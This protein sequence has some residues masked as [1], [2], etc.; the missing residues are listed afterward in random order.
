MKSTTAPLGGKRLI[1]V[2]ARA[3][4]DTKAESLTILDLSRHSGVSDW[5]VV[6][7]GD[8]PIHN[9]AVAAAIRDGLE[10]HGTILWHI[11]GEEQGRWIL[12]DYS[13]VV[14]HVMLPELR[15][16]YQ[17]ELLREDIE[18]IDINNEAELDSNFLD[19]NGR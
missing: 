18:R 13:D 1:D 12:L 4:F 2:A 3:A 14:V 19:R 10:K 16:Y 11:E 15:A 5:F 9:K 17:L 6:C 8:N 7:Q